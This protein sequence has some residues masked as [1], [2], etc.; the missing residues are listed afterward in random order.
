[1]L[2][3]I[4]A[5]FGMILILPLSIY[6]RLLCRSC[7]T[8]FAK[9]RWCRAWRRDFGHDIVILAIR[10]YGRSAMPANLLILHYIREECV[11]IF[12]YHRSSPSVYDTPRYHTQLLYLIIISFA[13]IEVIFRHDC[14]D[15][16]D[17]IL[18]DATT[19]ASCQLITNTAPQTYLMPVMI[20][21][22]IRYDGR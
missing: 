20:V 5:H 21:F 2:G 4:A 1:M 8:N 11:T 18:Q 3:M 9:L 19:W 17:T 22:I 13:S 7:V 10:A 12:L 15:G 16:H 6:W 14:R